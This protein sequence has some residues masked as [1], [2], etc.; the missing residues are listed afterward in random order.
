MTTLLTADLHLTSL[1]RDAD[2]WNLFPWIEKQID[3]YD[4]NEVCIL[5]DLTDAKNNH[6]EALTNKVVHYIDRLAQKATVIILRGNHDFIDEQNPYFRF[7]PKLGN[8]KYI[9]KPR[10]LELSTGISVFVPCTRDPEAFKN[11]L[12]DDG[13]NVDYYFTHQTYH[14]CETENGTRLVGL[15]PKLFK[16]FKGKVWSGDIHVPQ[17]LGTNIEYV[18]APYHVR[19]GDS[20]PARCVLLTGGPSK[21]PQELHFNFRKRRTLD[22]Y[23]RGGAVKIG[24]VDKGTQVKIRVHL[25]RKDYPD[26]KNIKAELLEQAARMELEVHGLELTMIQGTLNRPEEEALKG[27]SPTEILLDHVKRKNLDQGMKKAG[28]LFLR[29]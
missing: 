20:F 16:D 12:E 26:W 1:E 7:L 11:A 19:F 3:Q 2:R 25:S 4:I 14:G 17:H 28:L 8:V 9:N 24:K 29:G 21:E 23:S 15:T 5:G 13:F 18:G 6:P 27:Q 10:R 22:L